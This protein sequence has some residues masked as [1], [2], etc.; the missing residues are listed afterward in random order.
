[1]EVVDASLQRHGELD[2]VVLVAPDQHLLRLAHTPYLNEERN[3]EE[4]GEK[5]CGSRADRDPAD[6]RGQ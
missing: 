2:E 4:K 6:R 1:M 3:S 5:T